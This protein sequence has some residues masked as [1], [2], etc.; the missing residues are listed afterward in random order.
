[1]IMLIG[2]LLIIGFVAG[3]ERKNLET[4]DVDSFCFVNG[5]V[6]HHGTEFKS[7][8]TTYYCHGGQPVLRTI[9]CSMNGQCHDE[10]SRWRDQN[11]CFEYTC[12][13]SGSN[14][15]RIKPIP[16]CRGNNGE[17]HDINSRWTDDCV[18]FQCTGGHNS[19][20]A[21]TVAVLCRDMHGK[22]HQPGSVF[23]YVMRGVPYRH[24][25]CQRMG[26]NIKY[27]CQY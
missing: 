4:K 21:S 17:C 26:E 27:Q 8:C 7:G 1:M 11:G 2:L 16:L 5:Q 6:Y 13:R 25:V 10:G 15:W 20:S 19:A 22:C 3:E 18:T 14:A 9:G 12:S 24:C 23:P